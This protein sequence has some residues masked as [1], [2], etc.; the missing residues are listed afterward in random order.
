MGMRTSDVDREV[1][2]VSRPSAPL[3]P[4]FPVLK[5]A[6]A[7]RRRLLQARRPQSSPP[8]RWVPPP[9]PSL[10][11]RCLLAVPRPSVGAMMVATMM[12][13]CLLS[14]M[15]SSP[16]PPPPSPLTPLLVMTGWRWS[17]VVLAGVVLARW[18]LCTGPS[19]PTCV[20]S[21]SIASP[22]LIARWCVVGR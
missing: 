14:R 16:L 2:C 11:L 6:P 5:P 1:R 20:G 17:I 3:H 10:R 13:G 15:C 7:P 9:P 18:S 22:P 8:Q 19:L 12:V 4:F 21:V